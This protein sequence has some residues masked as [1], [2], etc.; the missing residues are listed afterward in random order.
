MQ[1]QAMLDI[2]EASLSQDELFFIIFRSWLY[3]INEN[4]GFLDGAYGVELDTDKDGRGDYLAG[5]I[6]PKQTRLERAKSDLAG[7]RKW[8][9]GVVAQPM[10]SDATWRKW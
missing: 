5:A 9:C 10:V 4:D 8:G 7:R 6:F 1:F 3:E 2:Q